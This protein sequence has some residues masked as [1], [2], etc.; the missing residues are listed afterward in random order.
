M[1]GNGGIGLEKGV[2]VVSL[3][4]EM[5]WGRV[6]SPQLRHYLPSHRGAPGAARK[7]LRR[8]EDFGIAATWA[9]V[10][11]LWMMD[12]H[13]LG[14]FP[15][16]ARLRPGLTKRRI[17]DLTG[18]EWPV[19]T[20]PELIADVQGATVGHEIASHSCSH[21]LFDDPGSDAARAE[22]DVRL[23]V[24][25]A[26]S[27]GVEL[28]SFVFPQNRVAHLDVLA[29]HGFTAFRDRDP[30]RFPQRPRLGRISRQAEL[31]LGLEPVLEPPRWHPSGLLAIPGG[32]LFR[33]AT[34]RRLAS[35][36]A[37]GLVRRAVK[38][39]DAAADG[40]RVFHVW[41]H[42]FNFADGSDEL[43][44]AFEQ[45]LAHAARR[46]D[47]GVI[48]ILTMGGLTARVR[49]AGRLQPVLNDR[50]PR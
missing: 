32:M 35:V 25:I 10:G 18:D 23:A 40:R 46:R 36:P 3:D 42:P 50:L 9:I 45:V 44:A 16:L 34:R 7:L 17:L 6:T 4:T 49:D 5:S 20:A 27:A 21:M 13:D 33:G 12:G 39:I 31:R 29:R 38:G 30:E 41:A 24:E 47:E 19:L 8:F 15:E 37:S 43:L 14:G 2:F 1:T 48:E 26:R 11:Y 28:R 22:R